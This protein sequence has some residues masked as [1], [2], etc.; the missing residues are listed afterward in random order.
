MTIEPRPFN[1]LRSTGLLWLINAS[2]F[3]PR[4]YALAF[5]PNVLGEAIGWTLLGD[6]TE[7]WHFDGKDPTIDELMAAT[8]ALLA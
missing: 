8:K 6:G 3:H 4:G 5:V 7:A 1:E 2:V